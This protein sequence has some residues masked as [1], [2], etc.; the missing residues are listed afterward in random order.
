MNFTQLFYL[1]QHL[2]SE[3]F[4]FVPVYINQVVLSSFT[5]RYLPPR[6]SCLRFNL[7]YLRSM[8]SSFLLS[9]HRSQ[10]VLRIG[11]HSVQYRVHQYTLLH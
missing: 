9:K 3:I 6:L 2:F 10:N 1:C 8:F 4:S 7:A 5:T 11:N